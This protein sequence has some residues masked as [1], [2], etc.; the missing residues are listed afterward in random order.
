MMARRLPGGSMFV[1]MPKVC[2]RRKQPLVAINLDEMIF[3][4]GT[5]GWYIELAIQ[6]LLD[7]QV[8]R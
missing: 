4:G 7:N 5:T 6:S 1:F 8:G 3:D 2:V